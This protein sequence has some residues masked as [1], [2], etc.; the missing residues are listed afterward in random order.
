M[1]R[2][3]SNWLCLMLG[4]ATL[5]FASGKLSAATTLL[6]FGSGWYVHDQGYEPGANWFE[7]GYDEGD[8][9]WG[10]G[11][12]QFGYGDGDEETAVSYGEDDENK[13]VT[14]YFRT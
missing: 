5:G 2:H 3:F 6:P 1:R 7:F 14:T 10:F 8:Y 11:F 13:Y 12:G 4:L 9:G